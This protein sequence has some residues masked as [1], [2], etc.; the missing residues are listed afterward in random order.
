MPCSCPAPICRP[1]TSSPRWSRNW[2][3]RCSPPTRSRCGR[4]WP[5]RVWM[6][7]ARGSRCW[8]SGQPDPWSGGH[9]FLQGGQTS[10]PSIVNNLLKSGGAM[11]TVGLLYPGYGAEDDF[12]ALVDRLHQAQPDGWKVALPLVHTSV[13]E[14]A[15][16]V[17]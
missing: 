1:T 11:T 14:D 15:H 10:S 13:D 12:P 8:E 5:P 16:R 2:A 4:S 17:D 7:S 6:R 9:D 3:F